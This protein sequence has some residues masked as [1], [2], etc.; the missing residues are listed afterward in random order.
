MQHQVLL[1]RHLA[2]TAPPPR[3][4]KRLSRWVG[5]ETSRARRFATEETRGAHKQPR[6]SRGGRR[7]RKPTSEFGDGGRLWSPGRPGGSW[8]TPDEV[9]DI[10]DHLA[11]DTGPHLI[12]GNNIRAARFVERGSRTPI[13]F[14]TLQCR[15]CSAQFA[16]PTGRLS[17]QHVLDAAVH[18]AGPDLRL[19][20]RFNG[21]LDGYLHALRRRHPTRWTWA[22]TP[23]T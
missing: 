16:D 7:P 19:I 2:R 12:S 20:A 9:L 3:A 17:R 21:G 8:A 10:L 13:L 11:L 1:E 18:Q 15:E 14:G 23:T 6:G 22:A 5:A 4:A